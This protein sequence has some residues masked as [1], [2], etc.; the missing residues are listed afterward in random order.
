MSPGSTSISSSSQTTAVTSKFALRSVPPSV[1]Q[2]LDRRVGLEVVERVEHALQV[3]ALVLHRRLLEHQVALLHRRAQD[4][5]APDA[6]QRRL[7]PR[8]QRRHLDDQVP[9]RAGAAGQ[10]PAV[11]QLVG[12]ER[13]RVDAA[14]TGTSPETIRTLHFL[15]VPWPPQV[16]SIAIPFQLAASKIGVPLGH[17]DLGAVGQEAQP[18]ALRR[19]RRGRP[20]RSRSGARRLGRRARSCGVGGR[21]LRPARAW[22][23]RCAAIQLA[24][25][26]SWPSSRS[27]ARTD[28][29]QTSAV[30]MIALVSPA[31]IA[32]GRKAAL[33]TWRWGRPK[34]TFDAPRHM[35]TPSSSRIRLIVAS[36]S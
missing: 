2:Q 28:S 23:A 26:G 31:A 25:Q 7:G 5:V 34:E 6:D 30:D 12:G 9:A 35:L 3:G 36:V 15:Q 16:E 21:L 24:P 17:A 11:A 19:R 10:P 20:A 27:A 14:P 33:R 32:I 18:D 1:A 13:A 29:T 4:H 8:L 22:R